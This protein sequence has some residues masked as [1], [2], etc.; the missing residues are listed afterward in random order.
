MRSA[1][2]VLGLLVVLAVAP[3]AA[4]D[5][6][7]LTQE[8]PPRATVRGSVLAYSEYDAASRLFRLA[9]RHSNKVRHVPGAV[10][11]RPFDA[12]LGTDRRGRVVITYSSCRRYIND[13]TDD[14]TDP[15][16]GCSIRMAPLQGLRPRTVLR[17]K[18][19]VSFGFGD[20]EGGVLAAVGIRGRDRDTAGGSRVGPV[21]KRAGRP[22]TWLGRRSSADRLRIEGLAFDGRRVAVP[23]R[24]KHT[25]CAGRPESV[26]DLVGFVSEYRVQTV[27]VHSGMVQTRFSSYCDGRTSL[28]EAPSLTQSGRLV[29][30]GAAN[31]S[32]VYSVDLRTGKQTR[33]TL[34]SSVDYLSV[35][36]GQRI[37]STRTTPPGQVRYS[38]ILLV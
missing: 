24:V 18:G 22:W 7:L 3:P 17:S 21:L 32:E 11:R 20:M 1:G 25:R 23:G 35:S 33:E 28:V 34:G 19:G 8:G 36:G 31:T 10:R 37:V 13:A 16:E 2:V 30:L 6:V 38:I 27:D 5:T 29:F 4:A 12:A 15:K 14:N 26:P 9:V